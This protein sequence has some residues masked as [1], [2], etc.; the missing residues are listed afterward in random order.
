MSHPSLARHTDST[1]KEIGHRAS[2]SNR[3]TRET[4]VQAGPLEMEIGFRLDRRAAMYSML[5]FRRLIR[6]S[7]SLGLHPTAALG[8]RFI[9]RLTLGTVG[10]RCRLWPT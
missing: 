9:D 7:F 3:C 1:S 10:R 8:V 5:L 4:V 6:A 2:H